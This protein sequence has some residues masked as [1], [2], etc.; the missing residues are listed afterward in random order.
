[1]VAL[2]SIAAS[3]II[4]YLISFAE[5]QVVIKATIK[6]VSQEDYKRIQERRDIDLSQYSIDKF[7]HIDITF[8]YKEP[9][10]VI[11]DRKINADFLVDID[12]VFADNEKVMDFSGGGFTWDNKSEGKAMY[13]RNKEL[14]LRNISESELI[15]LLDDLRVRVKWNKVLKGEEKRIYY[16][17]DYLEVVN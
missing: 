12:K 17:K 2:I 11:K 15:E 7:K 16:I 1:M 13:Q 3:F 5:P 8:E 10:F 14:L 6:T 4:I 9:L